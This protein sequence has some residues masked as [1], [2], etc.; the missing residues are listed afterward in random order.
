MHLTDLAALLGCPAPSGDAEVTG[1]SHHAGWIEAGQAFVAIR[2]GRTDGHTFIDEARGRGAVAVIGEG[3]PSDVDCALP[4]LRV[5]DARAALGELAS[6]LA[7]HPSRDFA[8]IGVTGTDGKTTTSWLLRHLHRASGLPTGLLSTVGYEL[9]DGNLR[10]FPAH[11][12]TPEAPQ[13]QQILAAERSARAHTVVME[14]SSHALEL[15]RLRGVDWDTAV[16][17]N[18]TPEHLDFHGT[19]EDYF[20]AKAA[21][22]HAARFAV[23]NADDPYTDRLRG[24]AAEGEWTYSAAGTDA[25]WT[26]SAIVEAAD[27]LHFTVHSPFG[28]FAVDLPMV[29]RFNVANALAAMAAAARSGL[30][31]EELA[32][33]CSTFTGVPGRMEMVPAQTGPRVVVD[34]AH[35]PAALENLLS[36]L[37]PSTPGAL[38]TVI[39]ASGQRDPGKRAPLGAIAT[40][41]ADHA[42]FSEDDAR[43]EPLE[44]ILAEMEAGAAPR[45]NFLSVPD[46]SDAIDYA[47]AHAQPRD[48]VALAGKGPEATM[49]RAHGDDPWDEVRVASAALARHHQ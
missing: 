48:T 38:W 32:T 45:T 46:R 3:L 17:T 20:A 29:G 7:G 26:A 36:A 24:A 2:G 13:V 15:Q 39:G 10:Q 28:D 8:C 37:R 5:H 35:T 31:A 42:I 33:A 30:R 16:W 22:I 49:A 12:T 43:D 18:L 21:L 23:L 40:E 4:Y 25:D 34:F 19:V 11:F 47:I 27:G 9:P 41:L 6:A 1:V 44:G 14:A